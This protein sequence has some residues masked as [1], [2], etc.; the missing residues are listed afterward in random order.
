M[1]RHQKRLL[2]TLLVAGLPLGGAALLLVSVSRSF[3]RRTAPAIVVGEANRIDPKVERGVVFCLPVTE[4][5]TGTQF[6]G[7]AVVDRSRPREEFYLASGGKGKREFT[8]ECRLGES[9]WRSSASIQNVVRRLMVPRRCSI[10]TSL[11]ERSNSS[12]ETGKQGRKLV[13]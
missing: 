1:E 8:P 9:S 5:E 2:L 4:A 6:I 13:S 3:E 10:Q 7:A 12:S 11:L